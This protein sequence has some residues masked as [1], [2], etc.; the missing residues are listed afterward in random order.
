MRIAIMGAGGVGSYFGARLAGSGEDV[1]FIARAAHLA[2]LWERGLSVKSPR[3]NLRLETV[4]ATEDPSTV[5]IV[6]IV[7]LT[8]KL[9]D[10]ETACDLIAPMVSPETMIV[11]VQNGV[12]SIDIISS[13][14][15]PKIVVGGLAFIASFVVSPGEV[16]HLTEL[17][18]LVLGEV[19]GSLSNRVLAFRDVGQRAGFDAEVTENIELE[20]TSLSRQAVGAIET[21]NDLREISRRSI[22]EV[23][24]VG[25]AKGIAFPA[26]MLETTL[27]LNSRFDPNAKNSML[28]DLEAG[29]PLEHE[30]ISG[31]I[32]RLGRE[33]GVPT[34]FH[35]IAYAI[36][37]PF[38]AGKPPKSTN[39]LM[40]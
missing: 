6:D 19:D 9:Y 2:A 34:P 36:L 10:L 14:F 17:H 1:I 30:W 38:A 33:L 31:E 12:S 4:A 26:D 25:R 35:E 32:V 18:R 39:K 7:L 21:D 8:V 20:L 29:R 3:G 5:G 22:N 23:L 24:S 11:P 13:K 37:K 16:E 27:A 40:R 28:I 15:D